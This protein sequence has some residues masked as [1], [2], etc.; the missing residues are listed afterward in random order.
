MGKTRDKMVEDLRLRGY[1]ES[2]MKVYSRCARSYVAH[3]R[4]PAEQLGE[5]HVR[6]YFLHLLDTGKSPAVRKMH[7]AAVKFLYVET[8][9]MPHVVEKLRY[10]KVPIRE[11]VILSLDFDTLIPPK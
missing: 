5:E 10:P 3:F 11:P 1:A 4:T 9:D 7:A 2:T 8:L 6:A